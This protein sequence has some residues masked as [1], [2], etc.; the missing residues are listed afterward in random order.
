MTAN[1][2]GEGFQEDS[3][4]MAMDMKM[5][6]LAKKLRRVEQEEALKLNWGGLNQKK[7]SSVYSQKKWPNPARCTPKIQKGGCAAEVRLSNNVVK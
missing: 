2:S 1:L 5:D 7:S 4:E 6:Y 3:N